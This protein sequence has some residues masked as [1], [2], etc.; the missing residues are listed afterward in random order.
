MQ[1]PEVIF[2]PGIDVRRKRNTLREKEKNGIMLVSVTIENIGK[3]Q[4]LA[5]FLAPIR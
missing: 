1:V 4:L 3:Y 2:G 5:N